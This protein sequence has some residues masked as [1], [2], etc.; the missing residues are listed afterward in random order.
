MHKGSAGAG[1]ASGDSPGRAA[2]TG[3]LNPFSFSLTVRF[4]WYNFG[5]RKPDLGDNPGD[6][7]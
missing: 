7:G 3:S 2:E 1:G 4:T 5:H 6:G